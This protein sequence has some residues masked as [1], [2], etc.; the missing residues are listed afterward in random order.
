MQAELQQLQADTSLQQALAE[1][2]AKHFVWSKALLQA[3]DPAEPQRTAW[4][5]RRYLRRNWFELCWCIPW[6]VCAIDRGLWLRHASS[7]ARHNHSNPA[8][9][10]TVA[11]RIE[12][13]A[14]NFSI[15]RAETIFEDY[16]TSNS[17]PQE[18]VVRIKAHHSCSMPK[19]A[20]IDS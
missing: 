14:S 18:A 19:C 16:I 20:D 5:C 9:T 11:C 10:E 13:R 4:F 1:Q 3:A 8:P 12:I 2:E 7:P 15:K 17:R 6:R